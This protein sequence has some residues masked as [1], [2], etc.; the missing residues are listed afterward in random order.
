[1]QGI[2]MAQQIVVRYGTRPTYH[3]FDGDLKTMLEDTRRR[4]DRKRAF[5]MQIDLP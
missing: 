5:W 4:A 2:D 3:D 1:M